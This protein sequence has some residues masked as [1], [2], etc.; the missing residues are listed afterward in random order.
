MSKPKPMMATPCR[1]CSQPFMMYHGGPSNCNRPDCGRDEDGEIEEC[2]E[3]C[4][5]LG[6]EWYKKNDVKWEMEF[7][8]Y[9]RRKGLKFK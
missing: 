8:D 7:D 2:Y 9:T 4:K 1:I 6:I 5:G 3:E